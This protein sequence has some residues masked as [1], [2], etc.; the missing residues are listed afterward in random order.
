M[1]RNNCETFENIS[2]NPF[3]QRRNELIDENDPDQNFFDEL[4]LGNSDSPY[5]YEDEVSKYLEENIKYENLSLLHLNIR[6]M[7]ANFENFKTF[8]EQTE[9]AFNVICLSETWLSNN[10]FRE[11]S[12]YHLPNY[13]AIPL[14]RKTK[15]RGWG[16]LMYVRNNLMYKVRNDLSI[17][18]CNREFLTIEII[19]KESKNTIITCCYKP[20][21]A[22]TETFT[23][24][25]Q[26]MFHKCSLEKKKIFVLGDLNLNALNYEESGEIKNFYDE[27]FQYG[28]IPL[29]N[30]PTRV[31]STSATLIDNILTNSFFD[32]SLKKGIVKTPISD[33]FP[34]F[35]SFQ[36]STKKILNEKIETFKRIFTDGNKNSFK[37]EIKKID[38]T[39][40]E[41]CSDTNVMYDK[42]YEQ[43]FEIYDKHFPLKLKI[44]KLKDLKSPWF[45]QGLKKSSKRKQ[46]LYVKHLKKKNNETE[47]K[48]KDY[49]NLFEKLKHKARNKYYSELITKYK[50]NSKKTWQILKEITGKVKT[51]NNKFPKMLKVNNK[52]IYDEKQMA[53]E[54]NNFFTSIGQKLAAKIPKVNKP[55]TEYLSQNENEIENKKLTFEEFEKGFHSLKRNKAPGIDYINCNIVV[56]SYQELKHP[57]FE[58]CKTSIREGKFPD[59]LKIARVK[60]IF[61][62]GDTT[63]LGN[64]RPVSVLPIFSKLLERIM[65][66]R[67][68]DFLK[69]NNIIYSKQF[70]FQKNTSTEHAILQLIDEITN[71]F[72][73]REY[74]LGIFIDLSKAFDTVDHKILLSKLD[75]YG[76]RGTTKK[77]FK[78][79]LNNRK[80]YLNAEVGNLGDPCIVSCGVPQGSILGPL[81]FLLYVNDLWKTSKKL[82]VIMFADDSNL[83]TSGKN[84]QKLFFEM[85]AELEHI[86]TW[87]KANKLSLNVNKTK[88]S[89]FHSTGKKRLIPNVLPKLFIEDV[90]IK[91]DLVTKFL[92][93]YIDENISWKSHIAHVCCKISKT[94]GIL[95]KSRE[96]LS[97]FLLKQLYFS[98]VQSYLQYGNAA[99][100]S[101][102]KT[103]LE[104]LCRKQKHA[105]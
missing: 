50:N 69:Q 101:T 19:N 12:V 10:S 36:T 9:F 24:H 35:T 99:W 23:A 88:F 20:P 49:K 46:K 77:W 61:K 56:E 37:E 11:N 60:P 41:N 57:L 13:D 92:G 67:V 81:L 86:S 55:F 100:G 32:T 31:T 30:K 4:A 93:V 87:F 3:L 73:K 90:E 105:I 103:K 40:L 16:V 47:T 79:Y 64:Y 53:K 68:Y 21:R 28:I 5:M 76:I 85:N 44:T 27:L 22:N 7:N 38:W 45:S 51:N 52:T 91:R 98:F 25:L 58:I 62:A 104:T 75:L 17:S 78:D 84:L 82:S 96:I 1:S 48:Y 26:L 83:F 6:S 89:L 71:S 80:Q 72:S 70:G 63:E 97:K 66:N 59:K 14:E 39:S 34:I 33:H 18:D 74:T 54:F 15:K 65:Y 95:Y 42:F 43:F 29:I 94:I 8:L 2:F 102:H